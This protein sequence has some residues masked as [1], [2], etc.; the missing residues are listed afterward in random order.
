MPKFLYTGSFTEQGAKGIKAEGGTKRA[1]ALRQ[2]F[3]SVGGKLESY[4]FA[5]GSDDFYIIADVPDN[6]TAAALSLQ[7]ILSGA[8]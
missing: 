2:S 8:V 7:T 3:A 6:A 4:H 1:E 5:F